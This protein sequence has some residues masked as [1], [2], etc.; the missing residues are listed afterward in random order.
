MK[1]SSANESQSADEGCCTLCLCIP[2][3]VLGT[4][5]TAPNNVAGDSVPGTR[6]LLLSASL[7]CSPAHRGACHRRRLSLP[8]WDQQ[9][10]GRWDPAQGEAKEQ[11]KDS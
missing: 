11:G 9:Q 8:G 6:E 4:P 2:S 10:V 3:L 7:S 1:R 5:H